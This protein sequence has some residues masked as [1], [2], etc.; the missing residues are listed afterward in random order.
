[1]L[2][3]LKKVQDVVG[4]FVDAEI[5]IGHLRSVLASTPFDEPARELVKD[6]LE[7]L[8]ERAQQARERLDGPWRDV[9]GKAWKKLKARMRKMRSRQG[10]HLWLR[11]GRR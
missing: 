9:D 4:T 3:R 1:V 7:M 11:L 6:L 5:S 10:R 8:E 2:K